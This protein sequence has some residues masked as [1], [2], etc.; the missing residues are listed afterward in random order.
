MINTSNINQ[1]GIEIGENC[2][3]SICSCCNSESYVGHG[4]V[5]KSHEAYAVY[6]AG[7]TPSHI[8]K[9]VS[10]AVAIGEWDDNSTSDQRTC[11]GLEAYDG[12]NNIHFRIID[13]ENSPWGSTE[14]LGQMLR[15]VDA[16][17]NPL[18]EQV[19]DIVELVISRHLAIH[20]FF[21]D[22]LI[23]RH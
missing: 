14:L 4:F 13:P 17:E 19:F 7:W 20:N 3:A 23:I 11:F 6:Y 8:E 1:F 9:R 16:L 5:Y 12:G 15:R 21:E 18:L 2:N 10:F 22:K